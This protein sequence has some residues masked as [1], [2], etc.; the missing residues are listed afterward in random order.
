[1][2]NGITI[3]GSSINY[4]K[5]NERTYWKTK[6]SKVELIDASANKPLQDR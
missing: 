3:A 6:S 5:G 2:I 1:M 4:C